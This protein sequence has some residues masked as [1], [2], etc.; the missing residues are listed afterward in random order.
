M[1]LPLVRPVTGARRCRLLRRRGT[2]G[3]GAAGGRPL[4]RVRPRRRVAGLGPAAP[5]TALLA[6][7]LLLVHRRPGA[8]LRLVARHALV[9]VALFDVLRLALLPVRVSP[10]VALRH[11]SAP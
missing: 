11:G 4:R 10:F 3:R 8:A 7:A 6:A 2:L 9:H 1:A 5:G